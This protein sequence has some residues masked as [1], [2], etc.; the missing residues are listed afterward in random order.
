MGLANAKCWVLPWDQAWVKVTSDSEFLN[1]CQDIPGYSAMLL[2]TLH[3]R[4]WTE[5]VQ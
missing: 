5:P 3:F 1:K 2:K 4:N